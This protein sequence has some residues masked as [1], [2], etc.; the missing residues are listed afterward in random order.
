MKPL[1]RATTYLAFA[2]ILSPVSCATLRNAGKGSMAMAKNSAAATSAKISSLVKIPDFHLA[3]MLPGNR[4][5]VVEVRE[6]DLKDL[7]T[8]K[9]LALAHRQEQK[10]AFWIFGG[11]VDFEEP[12][13]PEPG[14]EF[15]GSLLP[16]RMP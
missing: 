4:V 10:S 13:L 11:P 5:K 15:D 2:A 7:P 1:S 12:A 6:K 14:I 3:N 16:P 9:E 8:G